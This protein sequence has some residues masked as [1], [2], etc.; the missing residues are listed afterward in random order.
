MNFCFSL[1]IFV[2]SKNRNVE[3]EKWLNSPLRSICSNCWWL[4]KQQPS[5]YLDKGHHEQEF[6]NEDLSLLV[7]ELA[8]S[9]AS[10]GLLAAED[11]PKVPAVPPGPFIRGHCEVVLPALALPPS[12]PLLLL[13]KFIFSRILLVFARQSR[14]FLKNSPPQF[15]NTFC[16]AESLVVLLLGE[17]LFESPSRVGDASGINNNNNN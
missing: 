5:F 8:A 10:K 17:S 14:F 6:K 3:G 11:P 9:L 13:L 15:E 12:L 2:L 4:F 1:S 16:L 7:G